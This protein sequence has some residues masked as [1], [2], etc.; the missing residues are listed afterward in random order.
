MTG[1]FF[2]RSGRRSR[3][4]GPLLAGS[5]ARG[6]QGQGHARDQQP[7]E[8]PE[9]P[10]V[11]GATDREADGDQQCDGAG[12]LLVVTTFDADQNVYE[13]LRAGASGFILKDWSPEQLVAAV[14]LI[15]AGDALLAPRPNAPPDRV[16]GTGPSRAVTRAPSRPS[17]TASA[18]SSS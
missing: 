2:R 14:R 18:K 6:P 8:Q 16:P 15:A 9:Y 10:E 17:P 11:E 4:S 7:K 5:G 1:L 12:A 13:A 3:R